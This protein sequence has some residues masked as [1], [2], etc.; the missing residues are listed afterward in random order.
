[1]P[2]TPTHIVTLEKKWGYH[3]ANGYELNNNTW[4]STAATSGSQRT[5]Y[6]GPTAP[7]SPTGSVGIAWSTDWEWRG[8]ENSVK[9]YVYGARQFRRRL[10]SEVAALPTEVEWRYSTWDVRANVAFD[11]FTDPDVEH[12]NSSG[13][14]EVMI[15]LARLGGV[16]PLSESKAPIAQVE[17][18]GHQWE[19]HFGYNHGGKMK[20]FSFLPV[21]GP[22]QSFRAD[23]KRFFD[24][25]VAEHR[26]PAH[27]QYMLVFQLGTEAFTGGPA[28]FVVPKFIADVQ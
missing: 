6:D 17:I 25:L 10:V 7:S 22:I 28:E 20:V 4:G 23:V 1:M 5:H 8:G 9:S 11:I 18:E 21:D 13:E 26:F 15:W 12:A 27:N 16:W 3:A 19:M 2:D 14:Y 24:Y